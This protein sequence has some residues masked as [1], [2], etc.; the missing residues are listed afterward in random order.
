[1]AGF[2]RKFE[3]EAIRDSL[4]SSCR[5]VPTTNGPWLSSQFGYGSTHN[6]STWQHIVKRSAPL[7]KVGSADSSCEADQRPRTTTADSFAEDLSNVAM[8]PPFV[9]EAR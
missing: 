4:G 8:R 3:E 2:L 7:G 6:G 9:T 1:M 5:R